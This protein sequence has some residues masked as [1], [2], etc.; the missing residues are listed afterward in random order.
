ML[1]RNEERKPLKCNV[2]QWKENAPKLQA[3]MWDTEKN[4]FGKEDGC[5]NPLV[6][7]QSA[8][9]T[10][11]AISLFGGKTLLFHSSLNEDVSERFKK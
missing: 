11:G 1:S 7:V 5:I 4:A 8:P 6:T 3:H 2:Q 9:I 10:I